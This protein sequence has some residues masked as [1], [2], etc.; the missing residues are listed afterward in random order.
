MDLAKIGGKRSRVFSMRCNERTA[1]HMGPTSRSQASR[2]AGARDLREKFD[3][4]RT[5]L[6]S[7]RSFVVSFII[8]V[9]NAYMSLKLAD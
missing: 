8:F 4:F 7:L 5:L 6:P 3:A 1:V 2:L 9:P